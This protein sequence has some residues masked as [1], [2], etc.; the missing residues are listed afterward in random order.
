M[1][2]W[3]LFLEVVC[4]LIA[5]VGV[6]GTVWLIAFGLKNKDDELHGLSY[7]TSLVTVPPTLLLGY[8]ASGPAWVFAITVTVVCLI[9]FQAY[10]ILPSE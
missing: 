3:N 9:G 7:L 1:T 6:L 5:V 4:A 10:R 2:G 8:W